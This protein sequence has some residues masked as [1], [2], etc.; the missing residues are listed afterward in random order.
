MT[1][2]S[3]HHQRRRQGTILI[4]TMFIVFTLASLVLVMCGSMRVEAM[5]AANMAASLQASAVERGAEQY[6]MAI[7][8]EQKDTLST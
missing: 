1:P 3:V 6:V 2:K 7:L 8:T 5:A 4:V